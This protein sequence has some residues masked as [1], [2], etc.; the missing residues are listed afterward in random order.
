MLPSTRRE[1]LRIL[2]EK[3]RTCQIVK[4]ESPSSPVPSP[5]PPPRRGRSSLKQSLPSPPPSPL[6]TSSPLPPPSHPPPFPFSSSLPSPFEV[7]RDVEAWCH[8]SST[9]ADEYWSHVS[10]AAFNLE[11]E[12][13]AGR[14][15][16]LLSDAQL[17][18]DTVVGRVEADRVAR[19]LRFQQMLQ[20][21]YD[22]LNDQKFEAIVHCRRCG[23]E[24]VSWEEKQTRS[25]DEGATVFCVCTKCKNRWVVR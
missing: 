13:R 9:T 20:E 3:T 18:R 2:F 7:A 6:P 19:E 16:V 17:A 15:V 25:A 24:E 8:A 10:R 4:S 12:P 5:P 1:A 14:D 23:S 22:A 11:L 21:K